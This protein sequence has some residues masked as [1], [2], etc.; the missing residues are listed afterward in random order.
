MVEFKREVDIKSRGVHSVP[1]CDDHF[2]ALVKEDEKGKEANEKCCFYCSFD[3]R[4][5][6]LG[7]FWFWAKSGEDWEG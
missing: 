1:V 3:L 7:R 4:G 6:S 2:R 5:R